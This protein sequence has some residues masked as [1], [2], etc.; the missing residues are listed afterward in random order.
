M[1]EA[2]PGPVNRMSRSQIGRGGRLYGYLS[3][4]LGIVILIMLLMGRI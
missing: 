4:P 1:M 2:V 3:G